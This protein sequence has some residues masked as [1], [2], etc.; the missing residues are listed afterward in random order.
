MKIRWKNNPP[1][2]PEE[3]GNVTLFMHK[4]PITY[5]AICL[6]MSGLGFYFYQYLT[7]FE[8]GKNDFILLSETLM[9]LYDF[10]GKWSVV[11]FFGLIALVYFDLFIK[12]SIRQPKNKQ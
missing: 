7:D 8:N 10:L 3:Y 9:F 2:N 5:L 1:A 4:Y 6:L 11:G 12:H